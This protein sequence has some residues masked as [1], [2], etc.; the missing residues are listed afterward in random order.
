MIHCCVWL[1]VWLFVVVVVV[2]FGVLSFHFVSVLSVLFL[3]ADVCS[4]FYVCI[5]KI[6]KPKL[7]IL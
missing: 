3:E 5:R 7:N 4:A 1:V 2:V 6:I